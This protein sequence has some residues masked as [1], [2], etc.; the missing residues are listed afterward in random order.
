MDQSSSE[1]EYIDT[2]DSCKDVLFFIRN[3]KFFGFKIN[4]PVKIMVDNK[5]AIFMTKNSSIK[6]N[7]HIHTRY[8]FV[9]EYIDNGIVDVEYIKSENNLADPLTKSINKELFQNHMGRIIPKI[10]PILKK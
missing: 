4:F 9:K 7:K 6:K 8:L 3:L 1:D 2:S 5:G 10:Y